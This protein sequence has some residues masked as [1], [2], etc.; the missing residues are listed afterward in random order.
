MADIRE[1]MEG[2]P[3]DCTEREKDHS[4]FLPVFSPLWTATRD[5][6]LALLGPNGDMDFCGSGLRH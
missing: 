5:L 3:D 1:A 6:S 2:C 4:P